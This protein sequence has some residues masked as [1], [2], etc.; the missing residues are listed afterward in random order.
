M[1]QTLEV[2]HTNWLSHEVSMILANV[3]AERIITVW[4]EL[5]PSVS[6][7]SLSTFRRAIQ[8]VYFSQFMKCT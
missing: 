1:Q 4:N 3:F 8:K 2:T 6:F 7:A 5:P